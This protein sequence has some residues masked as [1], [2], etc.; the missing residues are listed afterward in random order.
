MHFPSSSITIPSHLSRRAVLLAAAA[1]YALP[2]SLLAQA[3]LSA[4]G[5]WPRRPA[6]RRGGL[7]LKKQG[8][9][10]GVNAW[11]HYCGVMVIFPSRT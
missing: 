3:V 11:R 2:A 8:S 10:K 6:A 4:D 9:V 5:I 1:G 7:S